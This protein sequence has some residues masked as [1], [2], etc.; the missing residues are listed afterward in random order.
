MQRQAINVSIKELKILIKELKKERKEFKKE[1]GFK[2]DESKQWLIPIVNHF[3]TSDTWK[4]EKLED[5]K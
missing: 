2:I 1:F 5:V 3:K 4:F